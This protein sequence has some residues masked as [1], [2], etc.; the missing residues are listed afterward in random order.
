VGGGGGAHL[1]TRAGNL[2]PDTDLLSLLVDLTDPHKFGRQ[3]SLYY[4]TA[5]VGSS[6]FF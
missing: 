4:S 5:A 6:V 2:S 1:K 3:H